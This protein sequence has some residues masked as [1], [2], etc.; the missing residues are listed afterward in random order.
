LMA[1]GVTFSAAIV[2][3]PLFSRS[4]SSTT[5]TIRSLR[6]IC[7]HIIGERLNRPQIPAMVSGNS[8]AFESA[9]A[10]SAEAKRKVRNGIS[11]HD[12]STTTRAILDP[13]THPDDLPRPGHMFRLRTRQGGVLARARRTEAVIE[14]VR[15]PGLYPPG[16]HLRD[17]EPR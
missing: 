6:V 1:A 5:M 4:S 17:Y 11:A 16:R 14:L 3:S 9:F 15:L 10:V 12:R 8:S 13:N 2:R 7:M